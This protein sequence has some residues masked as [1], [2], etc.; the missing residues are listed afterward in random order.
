M[1]ETEY[2][3]I[4]NDEYELPMQLSNDIRQIAK[5]LKM[6]VS[7]VQT[8]IKENQVVKGRFRIIEVV[9]DLDEE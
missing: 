7:D 8:A 9:I 1:N 2:I 6:L 3:V 5:C 4:T